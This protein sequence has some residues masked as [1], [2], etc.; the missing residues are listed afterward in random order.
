M[1]NEPKWTINRNGNSANDIKT[2][3]M[4]MHDAVM[5][6]QKAMQ[7]V[8]VNSL[9]GR[10]YQPNETPDKDQDADRAALLEMM[11]QVEAIGTYAVSGGVRAIRQREG[12]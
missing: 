10:N 7:K 8:Y 4:A 2:D 1:S 9:H 6:L 12:L 5:A 3:Y 11:Q